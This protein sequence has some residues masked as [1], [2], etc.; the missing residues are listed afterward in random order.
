M[1]VQGWEI[2]T[3]LVWVDY[4]SSE[5]HKRSL[6]GIRSLDAEPLVRI[7]ASQD[8]SPKGGPDDLTGQWAKD[9]STGAVTLT[10][11]DGNAWEL[12]APTADSE[13]V[14]PKMLDI[15]TDMN[16]NMEGMDDSDMDMLMD[17]P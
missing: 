6:A 3:V 15:D 12:L 11:P 14:P 16:V 10:W 1:K 7:R 5:L 4:S 2:D 13:M 9:P 8:F 17:E